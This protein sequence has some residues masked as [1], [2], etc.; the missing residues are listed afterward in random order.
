MSQ[1]DRLADVVNQEPIVYMDCTQTE[2]L[3]SFVVGAVV[4]LILGL[5]IGVAIGF[6]MFGVMAGLIIT[7]GVSWVCMAWLR[8]IRQKY[9]LTWF[10]EKL[11]LYKLQLG[12]IKHKFI[13][14]SLRFGKG[15]RR[16]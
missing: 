6:I 4:G 1:D 2:L 9:Y 14:H 7:L 16:G 12:L 11:F 15:G 3:G 13:N 10:K 8:H 5:M